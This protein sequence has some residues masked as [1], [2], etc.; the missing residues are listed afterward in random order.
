MALNIVVSNTVVLV[1]LSIVV[2]N[3]VV[4]DTGTIIALKYG[5]V[6]PKR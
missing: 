2:L 3:R 6:T 1:V 4:L 5:A